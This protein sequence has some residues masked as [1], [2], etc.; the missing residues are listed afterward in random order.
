MPA[1][2]DVNSA[3]LLPTWLNLTIMDS[4]SQQFVTISETSKSDLSAGLK[5][6]TCSDL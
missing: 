6:L 5:S 1:L 4:L 2:M 3:A